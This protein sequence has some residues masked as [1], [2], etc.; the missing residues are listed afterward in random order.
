MLQGG[1]GYAE[2]AAAE[3]ERVIGTASTQ[4]KVATVKSLGAESVINYTETD[5][6]NQVLA[7]TEGNGVDLLI[8]IV[9][10]EFC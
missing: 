2:Y 4:E 1:G 3:A 10:G 8:E 5:W 9:G 6:T 7:A